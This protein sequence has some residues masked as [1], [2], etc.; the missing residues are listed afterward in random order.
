[1]SADSEVI[2]EVEE[3]PLRGGQTMSQIVKHF[4][5]FYSPGTFVSEVSS[6]PIDSWDVG[7]AV[8]MATSVKERYNSRPYGFRFTTRTRGDNDLD[9]H[10]SAKSNLYYLGGRIE[11]REEVEAR[12]DPKEKILRDNMRI[13]N[14]DKI[15]VNDNYWRFTAALNETDIILDVELPQEIKP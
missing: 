10:E 11:T 15:I 1:M 12:N 7:E 4:V 5:E 14:I 2:A 6:Y 8:K 9:S 13:N 3:C